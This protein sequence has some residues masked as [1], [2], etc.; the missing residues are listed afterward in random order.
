MVGCRSVLITLFL[1]TALIA[2]PLAAQM[3]NASSIHT[4][5]VT[6][7]PRVKVQVSSFPASSAAITKSS[8]SGVAVSVAATRPWTL[9]VAS[10]KSGRSVKWSR[11]RQR[12]YA[13]LSANQATV[14]SG[15]HGATSVDTA[16]F[17]NAD[18]ANSTSDSPVV[19]TIVAR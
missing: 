17:F 16:I 7:A 19:L 14:A 1:A 18:S 9:S 11:S 3:G 10:T 5:S 2:R 13:P 4:V 15:E 8:V 6:I 12:G